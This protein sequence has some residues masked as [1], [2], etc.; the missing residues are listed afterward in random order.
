MKK[1]K[2][3]TNNMK[4]YYF[5][6]TSLNIMHLFLAIFVLLWLN[7]GIYTYF[8]AYIPN[9]IKLTLFGIWLFVACLNKKY[10]NL[11][12][13]KAWP[14]IFFYI[15]IIIYN[16]FLPS[17]SLRVLLK[18][19]QYILIIFSIF[20]YY[21]D[22]KYLNYQ[23][24]IITVLSFDIIYVGINTVKNLNIYPQLS[25][26]ISS[27]VEIQEQLLG[28]SSFKAIGNYGYMYGFVMVTLFLFF[29]LIYSKRNRLLNGVLWVSSFYLLIKAQFTTAILFTFFFSVIL[30]FFKISNRKYRTL[31]IIISSVT[32]L[33]TYSILPNILFSI[34]NIKQ[35]PTEVSVRFRELSDL[36]IGNEMMGTDIDSRFDLYKKSINAFLSNVLTGSLMGT[37]EVGSHSTWLDMLG[38]YGLFSMFFFV[39]FVII[40]LYI[41]KQFIGINRIFFNVVWYTICY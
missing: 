25:R 10:L 36:F 23:K 30:L 19:I 35:L 38:L 33:I 22:S 6:K 21:F 7:A 28:T 11:I 3:V 17:G 39:F 18:N 27:T 5:K 26:L 32:F 8:T 40:F 2:I 24:I 20:L 34:S 9:A 1:N 4:G 15:L 41:R 37:G 31:L 16:Y 13:I 29:Q 14:L 12:I